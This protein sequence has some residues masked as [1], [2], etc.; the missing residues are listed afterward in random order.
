MEKETVS[1]CLFSLALLLFLAALLVNSIPFIAML[2]PVVII[3]AIQYIGTV[4][5]GI[6]ITELLV[7][8]ICSG[9]VGPF[10]I[11][12]DLLCCCFSSL[13]GCFAKQSTKYCP[14]DGVCATEKDTYI[15]NDSYG[16]SPV[17]QPR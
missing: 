4:S 6:L 3:V 14:V 10:D 15:D 2:L 17:A 7:C 11:M 12:A 16:A 8:L 5:L 9:H 13:S 1:H